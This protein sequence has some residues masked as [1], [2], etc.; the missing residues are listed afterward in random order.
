MGADYRKQGRFLLQ[1][2]SGTA[3]GAGATVY[4]ALSSSQAVENNAEFLAPVDFEILG[5]AVHA[6]AA[7]GGADTLVYTVRQENAPTAVTITVTGGSSEGLTLANAAIINA[8]NNYTIEL[9]TSATANPA[10][11]YVSLVCRII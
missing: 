9:V 7:P 10:I 3:V 11:H 2:S 1:F 8:A 6:T 5:I 4:L